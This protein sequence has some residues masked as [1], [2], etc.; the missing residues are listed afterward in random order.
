MLLFLNLDRNDNDDRHQLRD[1]SACGG[2]QSE[3]TGDMGWWDNVLFLMIF[4]QT[5]LNAAIGP[6][7]K[8]DGETIAIRSEQKTVL[9]SQN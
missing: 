2:Y 1:E 9:S 4:F 5:Y 7:L 3:R 6:M 8:A